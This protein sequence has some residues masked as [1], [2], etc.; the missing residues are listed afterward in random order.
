MSL[1]LP[2]RP[3]LV[4]TEGSEHTASRCWISCYF[5]VP[6]GAQPGPG[7][8]WGA[9]GTGHAGRGWGAEFSCIYPFAT[10]S[11]I[12]RNG[13]LRANRRGWLALGPQPGP[14]SPVPSGRRGKSSRNQQEKQKGQGLMSANTATSVTP[15]TRNTRQRTRL[16]SRQGGG[17]WGKRSRGHPS[18]PLRGRLGGGAG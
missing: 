4:G 9:L 16:H 5:S 13:T 10:W 8:G 18:C 15:A 7:W 11:P 6:T 1:P 12:E 3:S 14:R 2:R 17:G